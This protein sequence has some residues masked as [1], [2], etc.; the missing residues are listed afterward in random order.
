MNAA[1][2]PPHSVQVLQRWVG[3]LAREQGI[4]PGRVQRWISFMVLAAMLDHAR[5]ENQDPVFVLKGGAAMELRLGQR[6][7]A[8]KDYDTAYRDAIEGMLERLDAALRQGFG[9]FTATRTEP[10]SIAETGAQRLD[11]KLSYRGRSWGTVQLEVAA[12]E[13]KAGREI[14]RVPGMPL[15]PLGLT[16][17]VD[18]P[19]VSI[20]YQ[21]AQKLHAC[22]EVPSGDRDNDRFR[23]LIDLLLL[24][25]LV[26]DDE[27]PRVREA[28]EEIFTL[29]AKQPWPPI[30]TVFDTWSDPYRALAAELAFP[31]VEVQEAADA[32][33]TMIGRIAAAA[34]T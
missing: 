8:T 1:R 16:A 33:Q 31:L 4:A 23:D 13:G 19:C 3:E 34:P 32:V 5:D 15:D 10:E 17:P 2:K 18:V 28:C 6:A 7:R 11:I 25:K 30:I 20:R 27:W 24:E 22:T 21:I 14:D 9:D 26:E 29:Q 12:A